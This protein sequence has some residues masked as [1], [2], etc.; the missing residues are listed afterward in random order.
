MS[1][2]QSIPIFMNC[3]QAL[4]KVIYDLLFIGFKQAP[5]GIGVRLWSMADCISD[6]AVYQ[7]NKWRL[8]AIHVRR[9]SLTY[10]PAKKELYRDSRKPSFNTA[11]VGPL[12]GIDSNAA[13]FL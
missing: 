1:V 13:R 11:T 9:D 7:Y 3:Y 2:M 6:N 12:N 8:A 10:N 4:L 5:A